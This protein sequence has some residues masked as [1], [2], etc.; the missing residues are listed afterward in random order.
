[1]SCDVLLGLQMLV[2][3][4]ICPLWPLIIIVWMISGG[5][6]QALLAQPDLAEL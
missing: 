6:L 1:M 5:W 4:V 2:K 3:P